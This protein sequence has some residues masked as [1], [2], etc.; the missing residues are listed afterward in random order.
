M[1]SLNGVNSFSYI[2]LDLVWTFLF[3]CKILFSGISSS[4]VELLEHEVF[5]MEIYKFNPR[6]VLGNN[7]LLDNGIGDGGESSIL[8]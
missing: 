6:N 4:Y 3:R 5:G 2:D 1:K 7:G 8:V